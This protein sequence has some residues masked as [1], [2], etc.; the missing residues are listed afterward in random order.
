MNQ[1]GQAIY[2]ARLEKRLSQATLARKAGIAQ[3]NLSDIE[4]GRDFRV[5]TFLRLAMA[6]E[7]PLDNLLAG[8]LP[9]TVD[10]KR[11]FRRH[12]IEKLAEYI[13]QKKEPPAALKPSVQLLAAVIKKENPYSS[14]KKMHLS[15]A[16]LRKTFSQEEIGALLSRI[17][18]ASERSL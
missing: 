12:H 5:S 1:I 10:K 17:H 8:V 13:A 3:P 4:K 14:K 18:K 15:W 16:T 7:M 9:L 11:F 2:L 6:L